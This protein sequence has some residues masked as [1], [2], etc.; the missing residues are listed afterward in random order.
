MTKFKTESVLMY[1][2]NQERLFMVCRANNTGIVV[3]SSLE[4]TVSHTDTVIE[5]LILTALN[6]TGN[7]EPFIELESIVE[8]V[9]PGTMRFVLD[10]RIKSQVIL[11]RKCDHCYEAVTQFISKAIR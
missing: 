5:D 1:D 4:E 9:D 6:E 10:S 2:Y 3:S 11:Y 7:F 8:I